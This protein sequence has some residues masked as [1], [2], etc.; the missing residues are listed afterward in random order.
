MEKTNFN[1]T[2][3]TF[4]ETT[5]I[6]NKWLADTCSVM[7]N[8]YDKQLKTTL[9]FYN[10]FYNSFSGTNRNEYSHLHFNPLFFK[11][12]ELFQSIFNPFKFFN[13]DTDFAEA[14]TSQFEEVN[15]QIHKLNER[16]AEL[17]QEEF[18]NSQTNWNEFGK[19]VEEELKHMQSNGSSIIEAY[20][21]R[22]NSS[23]EFN[24]KLLQEMNNQFEIAITRNKRSWSDFIKNY[25][26]KERN[27]KENESERRDGQSKKHN[28]TELVQH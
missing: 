12:S 13:Q 26:T 4:D 18:K 8:I 3:N 27:E 25:Q 23:L 11:G 2:A 16:L 7:S 24:K 28:K 10:N 21:K 14:F 22:L 1:K 5:K 20:T 17:F 19:M 9:D 6:T 15:K